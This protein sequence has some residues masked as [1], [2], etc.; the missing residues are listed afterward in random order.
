MQEQPK[1]EYL[2]IRVSSLIKKKIQK[3]AGKT[4][5]GMSEWILLKL[6]PPTVCQFGELIQKLGRA[7]K[8]SLV[9]AEINHF[10]TRLSSPEL[11][12]ICSQTPVLTSLSSLEQ[13]YLA[14]MVEVSCSLKGVRMP[15]WTGEIK[16]LQTPYW[17]S[18]LEN[19]RLYLLVHSPV[20]FRRR[21]IFI[22]STI[23]NSI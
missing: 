11:E 21:N 23:G 3:E 22:D 4:K 13:N 12:Q 2:Q 5:M 14:A 15:F 8:K 10:L 1:S 20:P 9:Y 6:F 7:S 16:P 18:S 17:G 19:L